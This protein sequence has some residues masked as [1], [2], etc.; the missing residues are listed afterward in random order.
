MHQQLST[1][2]LSRSKP[3]LNFLFPDCCCCLAYN[4]LTA[5]QL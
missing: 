5:N 2:R 3:K 1:A 4:L